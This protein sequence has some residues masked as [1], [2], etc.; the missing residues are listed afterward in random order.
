MIPAF[1]QPRGGP[2]DVEFSKKD[3]EYA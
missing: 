2:A 1:D 3:V